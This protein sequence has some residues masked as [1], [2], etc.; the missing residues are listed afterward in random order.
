MLARN[1]VRRAR[2]DVIRTDQI[3]SLCSFFFRN[4]IQAGDDL[5]GRLLAGVNHVFGL[6]KTF[7]KRRVVEH[8]VVLL[9]YGQ[10]GFARS[11]SPA[12]EHRGHLVFFEQLLRFFSESRPVARAVF[13]DDLDLATEY[14]ACR[15]YLFDGQLFRLDGSRFADGHRAGGRVQLTY[16]DGVI[17]DGQAGGVD[18]GC[19]IIR[20]QHW[21]GGSGQHHGRHA[22][23]R[24][25][26]DFPVE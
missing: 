17:R 25:A 5:L 16:G 22:G 19:G 7:V 21:Q 23:G 12:A 2:P 24:E 11:G 15:V 14:S 6:F 1:L 18:G 9:E 20:R 10:D 26:G 13:H 3:E 8:A 4:P